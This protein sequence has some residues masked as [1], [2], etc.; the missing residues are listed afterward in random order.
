MPSPRE[1][2]QKHPAPHDVCG[3]MVQPPPHTSLDFGFIFKAFKDM[4][5]D[6]S[7]T[8]KRARDR[9]F[10]IVFLLSRYPCHLAF[11]TVILILGKISPACSSP[12]FAI[13]E[14]G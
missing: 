10:F 3:R 7:V 1:V 6:A 11:D 4:T 13:S 12:K 8:A 9:N 2:S 14:N 5:P